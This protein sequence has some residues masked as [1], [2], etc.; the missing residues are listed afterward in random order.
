MSQVKTYSAQAIAYIKGR[1]LDGT[2]TPGDPI[3]E[4]EIAELGTAR[5]FP[6]RN[7]GSR[8]LRG[9]Q[10]HR[11][12]VCTLVTHHS[13]R[14]DS[15]KQYGTCLPDLVVERNLNLAILHVGRN[16]SS[17]YRKRFRA[18]IFAELEIFKISQSH[19]LMISPKVALRLSCF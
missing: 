15:R 14:T 5:D 4:T 3:R 10:S 8:T 6:P 18:N 13:Y 7:Q 2:L 11:M 9:T 17:Q 16:T 12:L 1:L 19:A